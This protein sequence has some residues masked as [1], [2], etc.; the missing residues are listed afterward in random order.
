MNDKRDPNRITRR[1][2]LQQA[3]VGAAGTLIMMSE[4]RLF[5]QPTSGEEASLLKDITSQSQGDLDRFLASQEPYFREFAKMFLLDPK[6][7]YLAAGQKG[8]QPIPILR[9][10]KE[11]L[12]QIAKD[13]FPVYLEPSEKTRGKIARS[14]GATVDEIAIS[15]NASERNRKQVMRR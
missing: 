12:D 5:A 9:R 10:F 2:F 6:T 4:T 14:Y 8:S 1:D 3:G 7:T 13:P 11:G 15:R